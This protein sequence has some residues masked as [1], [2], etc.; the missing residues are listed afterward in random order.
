[1]EKYDVIIIGTGIGGLTAGSLLSKY[2]KKKILFL[3]QNN[4][5]GGMTSGFY[6]KGYYMEAGTLGISLVDYF[7]S[8]LHDI[9]PSLSDEIKKQYYK[10]VICDTICDGR[11]IIEV[12][13]QYVK[14]FPDNIPQ[15]RTLFSF[16]KKK[17]SILKEFLHIFNHYQ[18]FKS[19]FF[20]KALI[21]LKVLPVII[22]N[23]WF[24]IHYYPQQINTLLTK[25]FGSVDTNPGYYFANI[26]YYYNPAIF[27]FLGVW[28]EYEGGI[29]IAKNGYL[30]LAEKIMDIALENGAVLLK[31]KKVTKIIIENKKAIGVETEN[32]KYYADSIISNIDLKK[33]LLNM[34]PDFTFKKS[35]IKRIT[36]ARPSE[37]GI[38]LYMGV[39][40]SNDELKK[41][42]PETEMLYVHKDFKP[43]H[44]L[45]SYL[46][47]CSLQIS[48]SYYLSETR[49]KEGSTSI[50]IHT[51][52]PPE[53]NMP[54][55]DLS[56][57]KYKE[58]KNSL[59]TIL[60]DRM[61][62]LV[63]GI[64]NKIEVIDIATPRTIEN[65]INCSQGASGGFSWE[66][67][68]SFMKTMLLTKV[69]SKTSVKNLYQVGM[70]SIQHGG[71]YGSSLSGMLGAELVNKKKF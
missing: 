38:I 17:V 69:Y 29:G 22:K 37:S 58:I 46:K 50:I 1:M 19:G 9:S 35:A 60:V 14:M 49:E 2:T 62:S 51:S 7:R 27:M 5:I 23:L 16:I 70:F 71:V 8:L 20:G 68:K 34:C 15:I 47:T 44:D 54:W 41:Y 55:F 67:K 12:E 63:P 45:F 3:E 24:F 53:H 59:I 61:E 57:E 43:A 13:E 39:T 6:R 42:I 56:K 28:M 64:S 18:Y 66:R 40:I 11:N 26:T 65:W 36:Q 32:E 48:P 10:Y 31:N 25:I 30:E 21:L 33:L 52:I 4:V